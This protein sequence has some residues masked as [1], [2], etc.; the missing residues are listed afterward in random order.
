MFVEPQLSLVVAVIAAFGLFLV[1]FGIASFGTNSASRTKLF[2]FAEG[3]L[4]VMIGF[5]AVAY[6]NVFRI[7]TDVGP[8]NPVDLSSGVPIALVV[9]VRPS[10]FYAMF[11]MLLVGTALHWFGAPGRSS[12]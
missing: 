5:S 3:P 11:A 8:R 1:V 10:L 4:S 6:L 7:L 2:L 9:F 12:N